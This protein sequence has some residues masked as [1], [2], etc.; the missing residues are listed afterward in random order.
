M[1]LG[2]YFPVN[3]GCEAP[4]LNKNIQLETFTFLNVRTKGDGKIN[5]N[6]SHIYFI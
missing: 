1:K 5:Q 6:I 4:F 2:K 3:V